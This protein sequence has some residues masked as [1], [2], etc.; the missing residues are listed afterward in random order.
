M[1]ETGVFLLFA[2]QVFLVGDEYLE[3][4]LAEVFEDAL[5][6]SLEEGVAGVFQRVHLFL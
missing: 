5:Y 6:L 3:V 1:V 4:D 2:L